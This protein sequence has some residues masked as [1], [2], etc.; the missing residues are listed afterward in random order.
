MSARDELAAVILGPNEIPMPEEADDSH[1]DPKYAA[2]RVL[3]KFVVIPRADLPQV[4]KSLHDKDTYLADGQSIVYMGQENARQW[5]LRDVAVWQFIASQDAALDRRRDEL[6]REIAGEA[7]KDPNCRVNY[8]GMVTTA[9][10]AID[11]IIALEQ[12]AP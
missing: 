12:A 5:C 8:A 3:A 6:A 10:I 7:E 4:K 9:R 11:R 1:I 2:D